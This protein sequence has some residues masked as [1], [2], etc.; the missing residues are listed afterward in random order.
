MAFLSTPVLLMNSYLSV[1]ELQ[2]NESL[3]DLLNLSVQE[4]HLKIKCVVFLVLTTG[5][6]SCD[7]SFKIEKTSSRYTQRK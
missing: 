6:L 2:P 7:E 5:S 3:T 1:E 4:L